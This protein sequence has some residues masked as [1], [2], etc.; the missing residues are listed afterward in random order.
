MGLNATESLLRVKLR[1]TQHEQ[2]SSALAPR[3]DIGLARAPDI[4]WIEGCGISLSGRF[5]FP[6]SLRGSNV[7]EFRRPTVKIGRS[8]RVS[9]LTRADI[10][11]PPMNMLRNRRGSIF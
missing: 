2:M 5:L 11:G 6:F 8:L 10:D 3:T 9:F 7:M 4:K 1:N